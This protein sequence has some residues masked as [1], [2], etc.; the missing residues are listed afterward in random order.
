[1]GKE[2]RKRWQDNERAIEITKK[3]REEVTKE[4]IQF[5]KESYTSV[6]GLLPK[7]FNGGAFFTPTHV[8][9]FLVEFL[10]IPE[11]PA[12]TRIL[13]PSVGGGV[14]LEGIPENHEIT[15]LELNATSAAVTSLIYPHANVIVGD[16]LE[17]DRENYYDFVIGNPPYG[18]SVKTEREFKTLTKRKGL[19]SGKSE[20]AFLEL[21]IRACKPGGY[22]AY[23]LP[24]GLQYAQQA[25]K[26]RKLMYETCWHVAT[27]ELPTTTFQHV[28][29]NI[30]TMILILRKVP[31]NTKMIE[32][33]K[34]LPKG[35][36]FFE[37]QQPSL[38]ARVGDIGYDKK[39]RSTDKWGDGLTQLDELLD[40]VKL[41]GWQTDLYRVNSFPYKPWWVDKGASV[42]EFF[43]SKSADNRDKDLHGSEGFGQESRYLP[44][45]EIETGLVVW[46]EMTLGVGEGRSWD[47]YWQDEIVEEYVTKND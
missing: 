35:T 21:A 1:M 27:I 25:K 39:G 32:A 7:G 33:H 6:G 24:V 30:P 37:G 45:D 36:K 2:Q 46:Q 42:T 14:F 11:K 34:S 26:V 10:G 15:A 23:I 41:G 5:L 17:H 8:A 44:K 12:G 40:L 29:T 9:K 19:Y 22:I 13:E 47:F 43:F 18:E 28:G 20:F 4:D 3:P 38:F 16:A 31:P